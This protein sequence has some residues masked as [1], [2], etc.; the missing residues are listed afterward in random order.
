MK[1]MSCVCLFSYLCCF[2]KKVKHVENEF[3]QSEYSLMQM[4]I[5]LQMQA[6]RE[7][8]S[9]INECVDCDCCEE[10][11]EST[12]P[13]KTI[14]ICNDPLYRKIPDYKNVESLIVKQCTIFSCVSA[15]PSYLRVL[16]ISQCQLEKF[17]PVT[18]PNTIATLN[19]SFNNLKNIP[20]V[21]FDV[22]NA[23]PFA[24]IN[25]RNNEFWFNTFSDI[26]HSKMIM[27]NRDEIVLAHKLNMVSTE[28]LQKFE[29]ESEKEMLTR[30]RLGVDPM[31]EQ[32]MAK[33]RANA[34]NANNTMKAVIERDDEL[35][36]TF[37][38]PENVHLKSIQ[39]SMK[40]NLQYLD[41][42][43]KE[44]G[45]VRE[46]GKVARSQNFYDK[47]KKRMG[48]EYEVFSHIV[49]NETY[50][51]NYETTAYEVL[52]KVFR[53]VAAH[54]HSVVMFQILRDEII[55]SKNTCTSG[56]ITRLV[57]VLN[58]FVPEIVM[59]LSQKEELSDRILVLRKKMGLLYVNSYD[60]Y[61]A[62]TVPI[63]WQLL[64]DS[65]V[66]EVEQAAWLEYV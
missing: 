28:K 55:D 29:V 58:G 14:Y 40:N 17:E 43:V 24:Q 61:I 46:L 45:N 34:T 49:E 32:L 51:P 5:Q 42:F 63:V 8:E 27:E 9:L 31:V 65:C 2:R 11:L 4:Q 6:H 3:E 53:V 41:R 36:N 66:N 35:K 52:Y 47:L 15:F 57:N 22:F 7:D 16:E 37:A 25:L 21:I 44:N 12:D 64:E 48:C 10:E 1:M 56:Q 20:K 13:T 23:N 33:K 19:L 39:S 50:H 54:Q 18:I 26:A 30:V 60:D 59:A 62:N 38:N